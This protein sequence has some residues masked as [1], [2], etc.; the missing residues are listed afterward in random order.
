[1]RRV[2][3]HGLLALAM[4]GIAGAPLSGQSGD[5]AVR[6]TVVTAEER[7][8]LSSATL[9]LRS[10]ADSTEVR[11]GL[12]E[13]SGAF[14]I[15]LVPP[16]AYRLVISYLGYGE[17]W[18]EPFEVQ[19]GLV[20]ELGELSL[21]LEAI[22]LDPISVT[23][24]RSAIT[25]EPDRTSYL[26]DAMV[27]AQGGSV[28]DALGGLPEVEVDIDGNVRLR[29][30]SP[31]IYIDGRPAPMSGQSLTLFLE[32]F[33]ADHIER[34]EV[35]DNPSARF[36]AEGG[37]G[38][39]NIVLKEGV[40]LGIS[41]SVFLNG[42]TRGQ[43]G[44]GARGTLQKDRWTF[45]GGLS[46]R[47]SDDESTGWDLREN[48][49][50][51][52]TTFLRQDR[53]SDRSGASG[54]FDLQ[55]RFQATER[56]RFWARTNVGGSGSDREGETTTTHMDA[57]QDPTLRYDR[58]IDGDGRNRSASVRTG[59]EYVWEERRHSFEIEVE[60]DRSRDREDGREEITEAT[61]DPGFDDGLIVPAE[62]T[63]EREREVERETGVD[64]VYERPLG[65]NSGV[66]LGWS[67]SAEES[68]SEQ[69][70]ELF[71][72]GASDPGSVEDRGVVL[73]EV[74]N[75]GF[76]QLQRSF[77]ELGL[78]V[79]V[80]AEDVNLDFEVPS[81]ERVERR[82]TDVF[83]SASLS[84]SFDRS[85]RLRLSYSRRIGRPGVGV[86]DPTNRSTDP[87][88]ISIGNPD[89]EPRYTHSLSLRASWSG[90]IG[91]LSLGPYWRRETN[92]WERIVAVD[93]QGVSTRTWDNL[94]SQTNY[95]AS[96]SLY[97][98]RV[99]GWGGRISVSGARNER[100]ASNLAERFSGTSTRW[101][102]RSSIDREIFDGMQMQGSFT[103]SPAVDL[104][105]GRTLSRRTADFSI[106]YRFMDRR[107][108]L[109]VNLRDPFLLRQQRTEIRDP[110][111][112]Q[113]GSARESTR[114]LQVTLS[115][116]FGGG[117]SRR[118]GR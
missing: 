106:R 116:S 64:V 40:E 93:E 52:P 45:T 43:W 71:E 50:S 118:G 24:E 20:R 112:I 113:T 104:P 94:A 63:L 75:S 84:Y 65:E 105:Q 57:S 68:D 85:K 53:W 92:G 76:V 28:I 30:A 23:A 2:V 82:Y 6:G 87:L 27:M 101:S 11:S 91:T 19:P 46:T 78:Q 96:L 110:T 4:L 114:S 115:Y 55:A 81:G 69:R 17:R 73:R 38:I 51:D 103:Y 29:D 59:F 16:G 60:H 1:M 62:L 33:P 99:A 14:R 3:A 21:S 42:G 95:G 25:F 13:E 10:A 67:L 83:P 97:L 41:G 100:D 77:G 107:A 102:A 89:I 18:T 12:T 88:N 74:T 79:G 90:S 48:L 56:A 8:P 109:G 117:G 111:V 7:A 54:S 86:L 58:L 80:R 70:L 31:A 72:D 32:Q 61:F 36:G 35:I 98:R 22:Q 47:W 26:L 34:I 9:S 5:G 108:S 66:E 15:A 49:L 44:S 39:V 37:G